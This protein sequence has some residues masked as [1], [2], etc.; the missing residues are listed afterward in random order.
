M[1]PNHKDHLGWA[2]IMVHSQGDSKSGASPVFEG[3]FTVNGVTHHV[4]T[5]DNYLRNKHYLDPHVTISNDNPDSGLVIWRD[6]DTLAPHEEAI[7]RFEQGIHPIHVSPSVRPA[8]C[9]HDSMTYNT[10][11]AEN[12]ALRESHHT[13][14]WYDPFGFTNQTSKRDD[15][16]NN[17]GM[18]TK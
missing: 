8:T 10:D 3:A 2:R 16:G 14:H 1:V 6:S 5:V 13:G 4:T 9:A 11:P 17:N 12:S 15:I 18:S 7:V